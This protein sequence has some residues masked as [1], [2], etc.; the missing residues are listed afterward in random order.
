MKITKRG[1]AWR[2][3][4]P[5][6]ACDEVCCDVWAFRP[7]ESLVPN[8]QFY[9]AISYGFG[10]GGVLGDDNFHHEEENNG[11]VYNYSELRFLLEW[12]TFFRNDNFVFGFGV[13]EHSLV[14]LT[15]GFAND[16]LGVQGWISP[17]VLGEFLLTLSSIGNGV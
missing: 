9:D 11:K 12:A 1:G 15:L 17:I 6:P 5:C 14:R 2:Y 13:G 8:I 16:Y 3:K 10:G 7:D 4:I